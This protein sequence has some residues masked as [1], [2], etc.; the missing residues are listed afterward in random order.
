[1]LL[2]LVPVAYF[3][4]MYVLYQPVR[5]QQPL[6]SSRLPADFDAAVAASGGPGRTRSGLL[7]DLGFVAVVAAIVP[8]VF[9]RHG[10][11]WWVP[12]IACALDLIED[13]LA[14]RLLARGADLNGVKLLKA[15][16]TAKLV[17]YGVVLAFAL[18][19]VL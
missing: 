12:L 3:A 16:A 9:A 10:Q 1:M 17:A 14:L 4:A 19:A 11:P 15:V 2:L 13:A 7:I 8:A 18:R 5:H 6:T